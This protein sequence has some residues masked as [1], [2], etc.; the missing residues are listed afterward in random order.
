[1]K[2]IPKYQ[3][4]GKLQYNGPTYS[5]IQEKM[6]K[7]DPEAYNRLQIEVA[8][9][10]QPNSEVVTYIDAEGKPRRAT[11][12]IGMS[13]ADP[14]GQ[15]YIE[16]VALNPVF[17]G[18]GKVAE[19]GLA[20]AGNNWARARILSRTIDSKERAYFEHSPVTYK[21]LSSRLLPR[22]QNLLYH[23][24]RGKSRLTKQGLTPGK[25][26]YGDQDY[27]W[28]KEGRPYG[29]FDRPT[30][31]LSKDRADI[32]TRGSIDGIRPD[33][34]YPLTKEVPLEELTEYS[35][36][37]VT[38]GFEKRV[39]IKPNKPSKRLIMDDK[40]IPAYFGKNIL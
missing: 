11:T 39:F 28:W 19:Y 16:G 29:T 25:S 26:L 17:K 1:M 38:Y 33:G 15:L 36:N 6:R 14:I 35:I 31:V 7:E 32:I 12:V 30:Y 10:Q 5:D 21:Y 24:I 27:L 18:L 3:N 22:D 37:P 13:G 20:K 8:R 34:D 9:S 2:L 4:A 23:Q 40:T